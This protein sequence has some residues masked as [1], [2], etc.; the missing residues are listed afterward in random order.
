MAYCKA[1]TP[2]T[3]AWV[4]AVTSGTHMIVMYGEIRYDDVFGEPHITRYRANFG[5]EL[6]IT[7]ECVLWHDEGNEAT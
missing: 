2:I 3:Q 6:C 1:T 5:G 4:N 7:N